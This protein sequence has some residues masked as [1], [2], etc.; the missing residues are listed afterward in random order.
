MGISFFLILFSFNCLNAN[1]LINCCGLFPEQPVQ[2]TPPVRKKFIPPSVQKKNFNPHSPVK[3]IP[4][5]RYPKPSSVRSKSSSPAMFY[6]APRMKS[7]RVSAPPNIEG[8]ERSLSNEMRLNGRSKHTVDRLVKRI[9]KYYNDPSIGASDYAPG[10]E[11]YRPS[12]ETR[13][14][15]E[16]R[17]R[18]SVE[19][20]AEFYKRSN[21]PKMDAEKS[22]NGNDMLKGKL[23][24]INTQ[25]DKIGKDRVSMTDL[26]EIIGLKITP[27]VQNPIIT[28]PLLEQKEEQKPLV[29]GIFELIPE[30]KAVMAQAGLG[31]QPIDNEV[32]IEK[33]ITTLYQAFAH[34][35]ADNDKL[36][37]SLDPEVDQLTI[38]YFDQ[39]NHEL[40]ELGRFDNMQIFREK[41]LAYLDDVLDDRGQKL[42]PVR[43]M[44]ENIQPQKAESDDPLFRKDSFR[45][46]AHL[47]SLPGRVIPAK[48]QFDTLQILPGKPISSSRKINQVDSSAK[49]RSFRVMNNL[50][51]KVIY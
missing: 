31:N 45:S 43:I 50:P 6:Y 51:G 26:R 40:R 11:I 13:E 19:S 28:D 34:W 38:R 48:N 35:L 39:V 49:P 9:Q 44:P 15:A 12:P 21:N 33:R 30:P 18:R 29:P 47:A 41:I 46:Y 23:T 37:P 8:W 20:M 3:Y 16:L 24:F 7:I 32:E 5:T 2:F 27:P 1:S 36:F 25:L 14:L 4:P 42:V 10:N 22:S 17:I